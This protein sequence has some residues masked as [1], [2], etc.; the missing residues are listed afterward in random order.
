MVLEITGHKDI[1]CHWIIRRKDFSYTYAHATWTGK[2][3]N[4]LQITPAESL[5]KAIDSAP[6]AVAEE[7]H[8][9]LRENII[10]KSTLFPTPESEQILRP[11]PAKKERKK[12]KKKT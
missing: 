9:M 4:D 7:M 8:H 2:S 6:P 5:Y 11:K 3:W 1:P 12:T 10:Q